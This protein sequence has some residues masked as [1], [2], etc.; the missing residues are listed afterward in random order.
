[1]WRSVCFGGFIVVTVAATIGVSGCARSQM[2]APAESASAA[3]TRQEAPALPAH[4]PS[5]YAPA[6]VSSMVRIDDKAYFLSTAKWANPVVPACWESGV[7]NG[8]ERGWVKSAIEASWNAAGTRLQFIGFGNCASN[9]VGIRIDVR[10]DGANDGPH[11]QGLGNQLDRV[12]K[13]MVL[14]FTFHTWSPAC[15]ADEATREMCIRSIAVH[16]FGHAA[17]LAHEQNRPDTPGE[18][19]QPAQGGNGNLM[20]TPW[21]PHSVMN[22]CNPVYN[23]NGVLSELDKQGLRDARAY[24]TAP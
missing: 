7:P 12:P 23:N 10:D 8:P 22:Y 16:E 18:C 21:D 3:P 5:A 13:G 1:M 17:G 19:T 9:A 14:N 15:A 4:D 2:P 11:T 20:L 24:G 6:S